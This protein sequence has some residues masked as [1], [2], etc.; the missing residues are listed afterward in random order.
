MGNSLNKDQTNRGKNR[1]SSE[2]ELSDTSFWMGHK[3]ELVS[4]IQKFNL[5]YQK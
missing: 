4:L 5:D 1:F 3:H 2:E